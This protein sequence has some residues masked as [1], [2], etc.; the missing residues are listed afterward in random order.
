MKFKPYLTLL[1]HFRNRALQSKENKGRACVWLVILNAVAGPIK[2]CNVPLYDS[3]TELKELRKIYKSLKNCT[4]QPAYLHSVLSHLG[5]P[6]FC[7]PSLISS[8]PLWH[9]SDLGCFSCS[10]G[11]PCCNM[12]SAVT[13]TN[14][15]IMHSHNSSYFMQ[16]NRNFDILNKSS[17]KMHHNKR[18]Q[19]SH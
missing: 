1:D 7:S 11:R 9:T 12:A 13:S 17:S 2:Y 10:P 6:C 8:S 16:Q 19:P 18:Q 4:S 15:D 5:W 14:T 3:T